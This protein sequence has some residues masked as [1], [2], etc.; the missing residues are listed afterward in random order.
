MFAVE[1]KNSPKQ[2]VLNKSTVAM[3]KENYKLIYYRGYPE[4]H[5]SELY[6]LEND[7]EELQ[8]LAK[9]KASVAADLQ[10]EIEM[11]LQQTHSF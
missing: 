4:P 6:D 3:I 7:P 11:K 5:A 8:D 2:G 9:V 1:A 10:Q